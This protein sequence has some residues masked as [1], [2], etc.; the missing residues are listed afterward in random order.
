MLVPSLY[1][2]N[3]F[4]HLVAVSLWL[5]L[6]LNFSLLMVPLMRDLPE[7]IAESQME[8]IGKRAR[9]LVSVLVLVLIITGLV[10]LHRVDLLEASAV[11]GTSYGIT[12]GIKVSLAL[13]MFVAFP[14]IF[15]LVHRYGSDDLEARIN[16]MNYLHWG[17][18]S[19]TLVIMYLGVLI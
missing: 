11:W 7:D 19:L 8:T 12:A 16:R 3:L 1:Q 14:F 15:I 18:T 17:I 4:V 13:A 2:I 10:N 9:R 5:G 6:T